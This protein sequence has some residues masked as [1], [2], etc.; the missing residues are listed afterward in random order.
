MAALPFEQS[1]TPAS[2]PSSVFLAGSPVHAGFPSPAEDLAASRIDLNAELITHPQ[3][4]FLMR[5]AGISMIDAGIDDGDLLI[6]D[7]AVKP[8]HNH[9]VI[10]VVDG[11]FCVKK[12]Y[13]TAGKLRLR[14]ANPTYPDIVPRD[15]QAVEMWGVVKACIKRFT[16]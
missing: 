4:T 7:R 10:A 5:V 11:E 16:V 6:I 15:G 9:I 13:Q 1:F 2:S 3:A 14:A 8:R 12:L